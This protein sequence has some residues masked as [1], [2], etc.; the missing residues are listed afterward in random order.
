[1]EDEK[2]EREG[3]FGEFLIEKWLFSIDLRAV[4]DEK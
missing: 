4:F 1:M 2:S 3:F